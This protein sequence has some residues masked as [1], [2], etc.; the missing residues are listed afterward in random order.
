MGR[1]SEGKEEKGEEGE[2]GRGETER[3]RGNDQTINYKVK[4]GVK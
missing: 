3:G 2:Q 1:E 4:N